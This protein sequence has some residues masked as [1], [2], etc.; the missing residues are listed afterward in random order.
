MRRINM[1]HRVTLLVFLSLFLSS[2]MSFGS[3]KMTINQEGYRKIRIKHPT[4]EYQATHNL[5]APYQEAVEIYTI[6]LRS[7][8]NR[9]EGKDISVYK[10]SDMSMVGVKGF[11]DLSCKNNTSYA[12][13]ELLVDGVKEFEI[14]GKY[15]LDYNCK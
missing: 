7:H 2:C 14:N 12:Q 15:E 10:F 9:V 5:F 13:I 6:I 11:I 8:D 4:G 1:F 3:S